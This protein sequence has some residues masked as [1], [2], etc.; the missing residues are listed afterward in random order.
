[1]TA[2]PRHIAHFDLDAFFVSV[3]LLKR[4]ELRGK[5]LIVGG[6]GQRGIVAA[7]S[8]EARR[9]GIQSAMPSVTAKKLCPEAIFISGSHGEYS[10][11]SR[12]VTQIIADSVPHYEKAS[13]DEFYVDLTGMDK[14]FGVSQYTRELREKIMRESGLPISYGLSA[15]KLVSKMATNEAKPNGFLEIAHGRETSFLWP[16]TVDKI[17]GVG[18]ATQQQLYGLGIRT[19]KDLAHTPA[20]HLEAWLGKWGKKLWEKAHGI[21]DSPVEAYSEQKS[22]SHETTFS[23]DSNDLDFLHRQLVQLTEETAY[24]LRK[25][26]KLTGCV[27]VKIRYS[28]FTTVSRQEVVDYTAF[29]PVLLTRVKNNFEKLWKR[30]E[31]VRLLGVRFSH[32]IPVTL[33]MNLFDDALEQLELFKAVDAIKNKFGSALVQKAA[34]V[35]KKEP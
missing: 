21:S 2:S 23:E 35:K 29:D 13:I 18:G 27:T 8:Y 6:D 33:Q 4:P 16:L 32:L 24:D 14:F 10:K 7:C 20:E 5:P 3:E 30:G 11:Y 1:M 34:T 15:N 26:E 17:P 31:K 12:L 9:F 22:L 25:E 19:I 28:D